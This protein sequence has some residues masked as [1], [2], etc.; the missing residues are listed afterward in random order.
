MM[1]KSDFMNL[2]IND[3]HV[4]IEGKEIIKGLNLKVS[5]GETHVIMGP[6]GSGKST[7]AK[8]IMGHPRSQV[9]SGDIKIDGKSILEMTTD[10]RARKG[11]FLQFQNPVE[12]EGVGF[13]N[14]LHLASQS[15]VTRRAPPRTS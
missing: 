4:S 5:Q 1:I 10:E 7:L 15:M 13:I 12:I 3:L 2:E 14:F 11:L 6:N 8:T 9:T